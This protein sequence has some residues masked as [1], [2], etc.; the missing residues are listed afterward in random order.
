[1][2]GHAQGRFIPAC[3]GNTVARQTPSCAYSSGSSPPVRGTR[4]LAHLSSPPVRGTRKVHVA[5]TVDNRQVHP[6]L[7]GEH[8]TRCASLSTCSTVHP[9]LCGEHQH[10]RTLPRVAVR[11]LTRNGVRTGSS[12]PVRGTLYLDRH[13]R[14]P[15]HPRLCGEH[16]ASRFTPMCGEQDLFGSSPPVRGTLRVIAPFRQHGRFIPACAGNTTRVKE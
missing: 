14:R 1:M 9:R 5:M 8:E 6:R 12:P 3:A 11:M 13:R 7:C 15:V 4:D 2:A 10:R 16:L